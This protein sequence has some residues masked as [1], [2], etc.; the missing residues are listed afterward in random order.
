[1]REGGGGEGGQWGRDEQSHTHTDLEC[2]V[3]GGSHDTG[4]VGGLYPSNALDR[5]SVFSY[6][7]GLVGLEVPHLTSLIT[8]GCEHSGPILQ[9][10]EGHCVCVRARE[11]LSHQMPAAVEDWSRVALLRLS[12]AL[13]AVLHLPASHLHAERG[14]GSS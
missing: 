13:P 5:R 2:L 7:S 4:V 6:S 10:P 8:R 3:P 9:Q 12:N 1:M 11:S 14:T